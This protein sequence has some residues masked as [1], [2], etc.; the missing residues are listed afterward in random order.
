MQQ[1]RYELENSTVRNGDSVREEAVYTLY[2][3]PDRLGYIF[4]AQVADKLVRTMNNIEELRRAY[5]S[6]SNN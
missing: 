2:Y 3:G 6:K 4:D 1:W 5:A